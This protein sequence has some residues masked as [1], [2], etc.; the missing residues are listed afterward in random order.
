MSI[1]KSMKAPRIIAF[2]LLALAA[3]WTPRE[4]AR[5]QDTGVKFFAETG[6]N[7]QGEFLKFYNQAREPNLVYGY[8]ITEQFVSRDGKTVQYFQR[9]RFELTSANDI[10]L[11]PLGRA[12]YQPAAP[13]EAK[14]PF[15]CEMFSGTPVCYAFLDFYKA[16]GGATQFGVPVA[17]AEQQGDAF[18]QYFEYARFEWRAEQF[19][20]RVALTDLG[21]IYFDALKED[22]AQLSPLAPQD[23]TINP[24]LSLRARAFVATPVTRPSGSQT[25]FILVQSQT[26]QAVANVSGVAVIRLPDGGA[27][28]IVFATDQ[29]GAAK[30]SFDFTNLEPGK[31]VSI[32]IAVNYQGLATATK[33]SFRIWH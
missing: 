19:Q 5:A 16:N 9:A 2:L 30:F 31:L 21:R 29:F 3:L 11:T 13:L 12:L 24:V 17:P 7:V 6:H 10:A 20:N 23:A 4:S 33:T 18:I 8:P 25:V 14:N 26:L 1:I 22:A 15:A 28:T 27:Q 32:E